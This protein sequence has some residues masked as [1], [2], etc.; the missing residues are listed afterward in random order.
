M[1]NY[2]KTKDDYNVGVKW[3]S[4]KTFSYDWSKQINK[5]CEILK[6]KKVLDAGCGAPRD[7][8]VFLKK[9]VDV[10]GIDYT[11]EAIKMCK[12]SFPDLKFYLGDFKRVE[13]P[14]GYYDGVWASASILNISKEDLP[15]VL[16]EFI[17]ISKS[18]AIIYVSVKEGQG[19]KMVS[20]NYG[21]RFFSFYSREELEK[22]FVNAGI[23]LIYSEVI[24]DQEL[25]GEISNK[26]SWICVYGEKS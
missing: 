4:E 2:E 12:T 9:G 21:E 22:S 15:E 18:G 1:G 8:N 20:D 6:G 26:P 14:D 19:E 7:I 17:R 25:T 3:H 23:K 5:F 11:E 24:T 16:K 13:V 10:E